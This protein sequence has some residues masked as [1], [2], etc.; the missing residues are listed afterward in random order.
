M[1]LRISHLSPMYSDYFISFCVEK[2]LDLLHASIN[3]D[4]SAFK[5]FANWSIYIWDIKINQYVSLFIIELFSLR[6][7]TITRYL[8]KIRGLCKERLARS[9][10]VPRW[11]R[12]EIKSILLP[13]KCTAWTVSAW[14][15]L[16]TTFPTLESWHRKRW[17]IFL[18][19]FPTLGLSWS[20][21]ATK[22]HLQGCTPTSLETA[23]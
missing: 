5:L 6:S 11:I 22:K 2:K 8:G 4:S 16:M 14:P 7:F 23:M 10:L 3:L 17:R 15:P 12:L 1:F 19:I 18:W 21:T 13:T 9:T 20:L